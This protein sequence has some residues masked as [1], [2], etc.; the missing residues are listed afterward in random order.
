[1]PSIHESFIFARDPKRCPKNEKA[2]WVFRAASLISSFIRRCLGSTRWVSRAIACIAHMAG[3]QATRRRKEQAFKLFRIQPIGLR[4]PCHDHCLERLVFDFCFDVSFAVLF[5]LRSLL[6]HQSLS[7]SFFLSSS[8]SSVPGAGIEPALA[9][10]ESAVL[11]LNDPDNQWKTRE[12][13][14]LHT[15]A[16]K[17]GALPIELRIYAQTT[18]LDD[19]S[20]HLHPVACPVPQSTSILT[21]DARFNLIRC[22]DF[23]FLFYSDTPKQH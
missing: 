10:S 12:A 18:A 8:H 9:D 20:D 17:A 16:S 3:I 23:L 14:N 15:P 19:P 2:A 22:V 6:F 13:S 7:I 1:M 11:P 21:F 5:V 4:I